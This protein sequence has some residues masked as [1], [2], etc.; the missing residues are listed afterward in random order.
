MLWETVT[1]QPWLCCR[2]GSGSRN[3]KC[4]FRKRAVTITPSVT[5]YPTP[6]SK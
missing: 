5:L 2:G 3:R 4:Y 6:V 1:Q